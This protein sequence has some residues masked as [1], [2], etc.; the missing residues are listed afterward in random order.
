M[1]KND[2]EL[3]VIRRIPL[4]DKV[5]EQCKKSFKGQH[6]AKYCSKACS[7]KAAYWRNPQAYRESRLK[8]YRKS[9]R[10]A[11]RQPAAGK[12]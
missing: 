1:A 2:R 8:N 10:E 6:R 11:P 4:F 5:C 9:K 3:I 7:N 12:K